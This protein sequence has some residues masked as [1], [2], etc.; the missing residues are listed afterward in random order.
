[1]KNIFTMNSDADFHRISTEADEKNYS[2]KEAIE[3]LRIII[4]QLDQLRKSGVSSETD[5]YIYTRKNAAQFLQIS[6]ETLDRRRKRKEISCFC[7]TED[8]ILFTYDHLIEFIRACTIP[9]NATPTD[10]EKLTM[11]KAIGGEK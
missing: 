2:L 9:A 3:L 4:S 11:A 5:G 7:P 1:M 8:C 6:V 10:R